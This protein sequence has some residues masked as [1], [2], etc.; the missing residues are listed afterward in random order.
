MT[1]AQQTQPTVPGVQQPATTKTG[2]PA[3]ATLPTMQQPE[4]NTENPSL[5]QVLNMNQNQAMP[6]PQQV[7]YTQNKVGNNSLATGNL[8]SEMLTEMRG[9]TKQ[10]D[11]MIEVF[12]EIKDLVLKFGDNI[13]LVE[14]GKP[15]ASG[16][17]LIRAEDKQGNILGVMS[18]SNSARKLASM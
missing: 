18:L 2:L 9:H 15:D 14:Q 1:N 12:K 5:T 4:V 13:N 16:T 6:Q 3:V 10:F 8:G 17:T 7:D 11:S